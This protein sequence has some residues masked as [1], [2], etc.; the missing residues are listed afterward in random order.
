MNRTLAVGTG[1]TAASA[2]GYVVGVLEPYPFR[3]F[4]VSGVM[5]GITIVAVAGNDAGAS[6]GDEHGGDST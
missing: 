4:A 3:A 2:L 6:G 5:I 1:L